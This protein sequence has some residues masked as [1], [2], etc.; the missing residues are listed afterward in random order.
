MAIARNWRFTHQLDCFRGVVSRVVVVS[1]GSVYRSFGR[2]IGT[3]IDNINNTPSTEVSPLRLKLFPYRGLQPRH[4]DDPRRWLD[5]YDKIPAER[6][7]LTE[8]DIAA[9][10]IRLPMVYG[11]NDPDRRVA[12]YAERMRQG[13]PIKLTNTAAG[14]RNAKAHVANAAYAITLVALRGVGREVYNLAEPENFT[15]RDWIERIG[16][17]ASWKGAVQIVPD[18]AP[19][20]QPAIGEFPADANFAQHLVMDSGKIRRE[21]GYSEVIGSAEAIAA[22]VGHVLRRQ[23]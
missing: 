8:C 9:S 7:F 11:P 15:E 18:D 2:L 10:I 5:D 6:A 13:Q 14:W 4:C 12:S 1:S 17:A 21:L 23:A 22:T 3:E 16:A 20:G 19:D